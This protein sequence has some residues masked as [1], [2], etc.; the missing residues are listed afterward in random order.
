V[1]SG[2]SPQAII[3]MINSTSIRV[4][5]AGGSIALDYANSP[6]RVRN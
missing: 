6:K 4:L 2:L 3:P 5:F 1:R